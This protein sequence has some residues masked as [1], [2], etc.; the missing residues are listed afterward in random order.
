VTN[1]EKFII[2]ARSVHG[3]KYCYS[4]T[5]YTNSGSKVVIICPE[6]GPFEQRAGNHISGVGCRLCANKKM[7]ESRR[8]NTHE[9][10][11]KARLVH[12]DKYDYSLVEYINNITKVK[13]IC[14]LHGLFYQKPIDHILG[15]GCRL[16]ANISISNDKKSNTHEFITKARLVH[17]NKY[18][19]SLVEYVN[20]RTKIKIICSIHGVFESTPDNHI[21]KKSGCPLCT[22][23]ISIQEVGFIDYIKS[24]YN[25]EIITNTRSII[26]PYELDVYIPNMKIAFEYNGTYWHQEGVTK[27]VGY[28]QMKTDMCK[29]KGITLHHIWEDDWISNSS[30]VKGLIEPLIVV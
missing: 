8:S 17:S 26:T 7:S 22:N 21:S 6:H 29:E 11:T 3:D 27:P 23:G 14:Y 24:L 2:K 13:I 12:S 1:T 5:I 4:N 15:K 25:G 10:I 28:H 19:Y 18:D 16:C 20:A 9:F 30:E